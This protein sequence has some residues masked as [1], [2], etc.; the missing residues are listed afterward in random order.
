VYLAPRQHAGAAL[1]EQVEAFR[2]SDVP[3]GGKA[4]GFARLRY[5]ASP[6][7]ASLGNPFSSLQTG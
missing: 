3:R 5:T 1:D 6:S 4:R 2:H 7:R